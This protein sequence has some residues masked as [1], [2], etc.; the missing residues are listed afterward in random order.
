M[1]RLISTALIACLVGCATSPTEQLSSITVAQRPTY[2]VCAGYCPNLDVVVR[3]DGQVTVL[4]QGNRPST[5]LHLTDEQAAQFIHILSGHRPVL[6]EAGPPACGF[7]NATDPLVLKAYPY[8]VTWTD[9][10][11][12][13][14][15]LRSCGG[16]G[17]SLPEAIR[18]ALWSIGLYLGGEPRN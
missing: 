5:H 14:V 9:V 16:P 13:T 17:D 18:Q 4:R 8:Q 11:S 1:K 3:P 10:D 12:R 7:W 15:R 6:R 2:A